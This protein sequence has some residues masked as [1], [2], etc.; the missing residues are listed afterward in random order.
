M[1]IT[2]TLLTYDACGWCFTGM[3]SNLI[4][5]KN[6][7]PSMEA[8][9][10][11][12]K[13][14][15]KT[16]IGISRSKGDINTDNPTNRETIRAEIRCSFT[17]IKCGFS[18]GAWVLDITVNADTWAID[19]TVAAQIHGRPKNPQMLLMQHIITMSKWKP[20][21][22]FILRSFLSMINLETTTKVMLISLLFTKTR[23]R[24]SVLDMQDVLLSAVYVPES[25]QGV[26]T[27][28]EH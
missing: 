11:Y 14:P 24:R 18:P 13:T 17:S 25:I 26:T 7:I 16:A 27:T 12:R 3:N 20:P 10:M 5:S 6:C 28:W 23:W 1:K 9:P 22:F 15:N 8:K 21:P 19:R 2:L 4:L